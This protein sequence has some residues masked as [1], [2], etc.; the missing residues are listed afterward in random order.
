MSLTA[1]KTPV[2]TYHKIAEIPQGTT[3][4]GLYVPPRLFAAHVAYMARRYDLVTLADYLEARNAEGRAVLTFDDGT[5][6]F[7]ANAAPI[8]G[9]HNARATVFLVTA[10]KTN[11]WDSENG[12][13]EVPLLT[14]DEIRSLSA[15]HE[16]GSHTRTHTDLARLEEVRFFDEIAL[17]RAD[18]EALSGKPCRSFCYPYGRKRA[19]S[20][21]AVRAA[22]YEGAV[23]TEKGTNGV[24]TDAF[25]LRRIAVRNDT[26]LPVLVYKLWRAR[27]LDR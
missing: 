17:S 15:A 10:E 14:P 13:V 26:P 18:T 11:R 20:V 9:R 22:G 27:R 19:A 4:P 23:T 2:L 21:A 16:F 12:D 8:L 24:G 3:F 6:D 5:A 25:R 7:A 1:T